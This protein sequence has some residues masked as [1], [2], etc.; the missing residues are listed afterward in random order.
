MVGKSLQCLP[1]MLRCFSW[2]MVIFHS[3]AS[4]QAIPAPLRETLGKQWPRTGHSLYRLLYI[5]IRSPFEQGSR[6]CLVDDYMR[7]EDSMHELGI[8]FSTSMKGR[9]IGQIAT[10][11]FPKANLARDHNDEVAAAAIRAL[12]DFGKEG[13]SPGR[14]GQKWNDCTI[15]HQ[16]LTI[17][18]EL[19]HK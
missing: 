8:P 19:N 16:E 3:Y 18:T 2:E 6:P 5:T 10:Q 14:G 4:E 13:G 12:G 15:K 17:P 7:L 9:P 1:S 11:V